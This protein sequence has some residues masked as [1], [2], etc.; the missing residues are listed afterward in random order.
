MSI[1][2]VPGVS[3][4][5]VDSGLATATGIS[6]ATLGTVNIYPDTA[7]GITATNPTT[8]KYFSVPSAIGSEY[9]ILYLNTA[10]SAVEVKRYPSTTAVNNIIADIAVIADRSTD[11]YY[12]GGKVAQAVVDSASR[13]A[14]AV[15]DDGT[16]K[17][18]KLELSASVLDTV[19]GMIDEST[20]DFASIDKIWPTTALGA[21]AQ[22]ARRRV[23]FVMIGD[24]NQR[25]DGYG[26]G[27]GLMRALHDRFG[28][29]ATSVSTQTPITLSS[30]TATGELNYG[31]TGSATYQGA[32][33]GVETVFPGFS[34]S[35][36]G[37]PSGIGYA[38][39]ADGLTVSSGASGGGVAVGVNHAIGVSNLLRAHYD[40]VSVNS[41]AGQFRFGVRL[42][43]TPFTTIV[44]GP[45]TPTN[46]G[47]YSLHRQTL[48]IPAAVRTN[49]LECKWYTQNST[50]LTGPFAAA[51]VR[52]ENPAKLSGVSVSTI[53]GAGGQSLYDMADYLLTAPTQ[54]LINW[55]G[56]TRRLQLLAGQKPIV[57]VYVNSALNDQNETLTP[58]FGWR[59]S[60][61]PDSA[62]AY[63]DNLEAIAKRIS[64]VWQ[65]AG[66][67]HEEL[68]FL[69]MPSHPI[70]NPDAAKL[71]SYRKAAFSFAE[72]RQRTSFIDMTLVTDADE[73][74][75]NNWY[76]SVGDHFHL[77]QAAYTAVGARIV[78]LIPELDV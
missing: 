29:Y 57:V 50:V 15:M 3:K 47:E 66:W 75:A 25:K 37:A 49:G 35:I 9:L 7:T 70:S 67:D 53:Y 5:Y 16:V 65:K 34:F 72:G 64:D 27:G 21:L 61:T 23:D 1:L 60:T 74:T 68:F 63:L 26:W 73:L 43:G 71:I 31:V 52:L 78:N 20:A 18:P 59:S 36:A 69:A 32:P 17:I 6:A 41:G 4:A 19:Q 8:N 77:V 11:Q 54:I 62:T 48:D 10:G 30:Y 22:A 2:D 12:D 28:C 56:E 38:W 39:L 76:F 13:V 46:T 55:F 44:Q 45:V 33:A 40:W 24:S 14:L 42:D 51:W 58:S